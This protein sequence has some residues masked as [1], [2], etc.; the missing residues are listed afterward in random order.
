MQT[1]KKVVLLIL[2]LTFSFAGQSQDIKSLITEGNRLNASGDFK[3]AI[4]QYESALAIEPNNITVK[5]NLAFSLEAAGRGRESVPYLE[6]VVKSDASKTII[7]SSY[8][9]LGGIYDQQGLTRQSIDSYLNGLRIA[10]AD[11]HLLYGLGLVYFRS[12]R[13]DEAEKAAV[14]AFASDRE[15]PATIRLYSLVSFHQNKRAQALLGLCTFLLLEPRGPHAEEAYNNIQSILRG[16]TLK[17]E[18]GIKLPKLDSEAIAFNQIIR[19]AV[20]IAANKPVKK[21]DLFTEQLQT[22]FSMMGEYSEKQQ[23]SSFF[24]TEIVPFFHKLSQSPDLITYSYYIRQKTDKNAAT[25]LTAHHQ[26]TEQLK[27]WIAKYE[28]GN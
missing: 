13:Y 14:K 25:W 7:T 10:P 27:D 20:Q 2:M 9:L 12:R 18:P 3:G 16:G 15:H 26:Q 5:Y 28:K 1:G 19:S 8:Q 22:I 24:T 11:H 21:P 4:N 17:Q 6:D 23:K